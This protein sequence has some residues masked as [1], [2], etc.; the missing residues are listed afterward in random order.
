MKLTL[1]SFSKDGEW[2][3][4]VFDGQK[5]AELKVR[6]FPQSRGD[7]VITAT[8]EMRLP[9]DEAFKRFDY[10]WIE[11]RAID[12]DQDSGLVDATGKAITKPSTD[13]KREIYDWAQK[14]EAFGAI[15]KCVMA[16]VNNVAEVKTGDEKD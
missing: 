15:V 13:L 4:L 16:V 2:H 9:G 7:I 1:G 3:P 5:V 6:P 10:C 8:G 11:A 14:N 12:G